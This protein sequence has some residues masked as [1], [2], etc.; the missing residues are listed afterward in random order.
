MPAAD[1]GCTWA[2]KSLQLQ[3]DINGT[4]APYVPDA[5]HPDGA[6]TGPGRQA[7]KTVRRLD[8]EAA[9]LGIGR[10]IERVDCAI[11]RSAGA[12]R[13]RRRAA[14]PDTDHCDGARA[15]PGRPRA[16][17]RTLLPRRGRAITEA[18][19]RRVACHRRGV[20]FHR[21]QAYQAGGERPGGARAGADGAG[22]RFAPGSWAARVADHY[23]S[24]SEH[25]IIG[26]RIDTV[27]A[28]SPAWRGLQIRPARGGW[29]SRFAKDRTV[30]T[31][32]RTI[33]TCA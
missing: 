30:A 24:A 10:P 5:A 26:R 13:P 8:R 17:C 4:I 1:A 28:V 19:S 11:D 22:G 21:A 18:D 29:R 25:G 14:R 27:V 3:K 32:A 12:V 7:S 16:I 2:Q 15:G 20:A 33:G 23:H 31:A 6:Q 9:A